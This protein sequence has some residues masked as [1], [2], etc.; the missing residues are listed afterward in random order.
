[1]KTKLISLKKTYRIECKVGDE[2]KIY[3]ECDSAEIALMC[4]KKANYVHFVKKFRA[5]EISTEQKE[6]L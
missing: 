5:I 2:W 1:M 6:L 3:S 4:V